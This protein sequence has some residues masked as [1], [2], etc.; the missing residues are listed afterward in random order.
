MT[1]STEDHLVL[2]LLI[3]LAVSAPAQQNTGKASLAARSRS[4]TMNV[5]IMPSL[6]PNINAHADGRAPSLRHAPEFSSRI[7]TWAIQS[8]QYT[9][10]QIRQYMDR[11]MQEEVEQV[12]R[13]DAEGF[14]PIFAAVQVRS[15]SLLRILVERGA[16]PNATTTQHGVP[17]LAFAVMDA[18]RD[19]SYTLDLVATLL[20]LG[21]NPCGIPSDMWENFLEVPRKECENW[22]RVDIAG[23]WANSGTEFRE[24]LSRTL[25]LS[26]RYYLEK[27]S[28]QERAGMRT[29][30]VVETH[31]MR[32]LLEV[33]YHIIGQE[34]AVENVIDQIQTHTAMLTQKPLVLVFAGPSGHGK[35]ELA[36]QMGSILNLN[37]ESVDCTQLRWAT[38]LLGPM[39]PWKGYEP[40]SVVNNFLCANTGKRCVVF[41][42]EFEK[43]TPEGWNALL[44]VTDDGE[45]EHI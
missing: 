3:L 12:L 8:G 16:D 15:V 5:P 27:A 9:D 18:D 32:Q 4:L 43:A 41:M 1:V 20:G 29:L 45:F 23:H 24:V 6:I 21:A 7:I 14:S 22:A 25:N 28:R 39:A 30:D 17:V 13:G 11:F 44:L 35:T 10:L 34:S 2:M 42:D 26:Q 37:Q 40:G 38:D 33:P 36:K 31:Q 19:G